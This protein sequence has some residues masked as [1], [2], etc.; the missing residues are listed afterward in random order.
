MAKEIPSV[1][2]LRRKSEVTDDKITAAVDAVLA[3]ATEAYPLAK[4]WSPDLVEMVCT[5]KQVTMEAWDGASSDHVC[6]SGEGITDELQA[7]RP[8]YHA[9]FDGHAKESLY[10][11]PLTQRSAYFIV[12][13]GY[14]T[15]SAISSSVNII[16]S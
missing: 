5:S 4:G 15:S 14:F 16:T 12:N 2:D 11:A 13:G 3:F 7:F 1:A 10:I 8:D 9:A 6:A